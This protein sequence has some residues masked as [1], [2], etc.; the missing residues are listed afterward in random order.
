MRSVG[1]V[2]LDPLTDAGPR[3]KRDSLIA[4][5]ALV[6]RVIVVMRDMRDCEPMNVKLLNSWSVG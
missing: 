6:R 4:A 1:V 2:V 5:T 3:P